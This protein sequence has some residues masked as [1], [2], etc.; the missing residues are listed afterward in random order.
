M[1]KNLFFSFLI[2]FSIN[3]YCLLLT[4]YENFYETD[5]AYVIE[6]LKKI[7]E[8]L[9]IMESTAEHSLFNFYQKSVF[10]LENNQIYSTE[11]EGFRL[12][13]TKGFPI[14][15]LIWYSKTK[16]INFVWQIN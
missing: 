16:L 14:L 4:E 1:V 9:W 12:D 3:S 13:N 5:G 7:D 15:T 6:T 11:M 10:Y 8:K 2:F